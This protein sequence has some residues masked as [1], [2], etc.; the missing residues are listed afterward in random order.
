MNSRTLVEIVGVAVN[1]SQKPSAWLQTEGFLAPQQRNAFISMIV[2]ENL[3][4][5][6]SEEVQ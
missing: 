1:L 6:G 3:E 2:S 4:M 5:V